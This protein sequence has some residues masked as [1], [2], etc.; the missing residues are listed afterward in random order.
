MDA[1]DDLEQ[2]TQ[3]KA[4]RQRSAAS[5]FAFGRG[6]SASSEASRGSRARRAAPAAGRSH[7]AKPQ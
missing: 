1:L 7:S 5:E 2:P 3:E 4:E 6:S